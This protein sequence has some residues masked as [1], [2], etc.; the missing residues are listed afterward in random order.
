ME[1]KRGEAN[2]DPAI[3]GSARKVEHYEIAGCDNAKA[4][5]LQLGLRDAAALL[6]NALGSDARG[7]D[8]GAD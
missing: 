1:E 6:G 2:A 3:A 5:A 8:A 7:P 4:L